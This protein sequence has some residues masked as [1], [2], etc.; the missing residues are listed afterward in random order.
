M[1]FKNFDHFLHK[2]P[3]QKIR[4]LKTDYWLQ[5]YRLYCENLYL[6]GFYVFSLRPNYEW[7]IPR[8]IDNHHWLSMDEYWDTKGVRSSL[9]WCIC[10]NIFG[11]LIIFRDIF[12]ADTCMFFYKLKYTSTY[13][14]SEDNPRH[15]D[16]YAIYIC[17]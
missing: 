16:V 12:A 3:I 5:H 7:T 2:F 6:H 10:N 11:R 8:K 17:I 13:Q 15:Y 9:Y 1:V 4:R 14:K